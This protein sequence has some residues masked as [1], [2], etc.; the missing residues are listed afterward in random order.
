[1]HSIRLRLLTLL[2][3]A[4]GLAWLIAAWFTHLESRDEINQLFDAKLS[5]SAQVLLSTTRHDLHERVE[6]GQEYVAVHEYE[7]KVL[8]QIWYENTLLLR[9]A[10]APLSPITTT[11]AG[12]SV[13]LFRGQSWRVLTRWD[14]RKE[15]M[16][17]VAEPMSGR[18]NLAQHITY[19]L[20]MPT[21][22]VLP[23]LMFLLWVAIE[24][25]LRPLQRIKKEIKNRSPNNL[26]VVD[27]ADVPEEVLPLVGAL[28]DLLLRLE[29]AFNSERR[30]TADAAHELRTPLA[31]LKIQAQVALRS[32]DQA[33]RQTAL[34]KVLRG[35]DRATRLVEQLLIL[36]RVDPET[37]AANYQALNLHELAANA[38]KDVAKMA[39]A[40]Q[41][42]L[43]L[44]GE[45]TCLVLGDTMQLALL[46]RNLLDNAIRYSPVAGRVS[47]TLHQGPGVEL[48][49]RDTGPGIP[50]NERE[51]VLQRFYRISGSGEEGSGLG[52]SI[53][54]R[55]AT[56]HGAQLRL[57]DNEQGQGLLV[58]VNW[59][60]IQS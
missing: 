38:I 20:L 28:N 57:A 1:M 54:Q 47:V 37:V 56:L 21:F 7:Q 59:P 3:L 58:C 31:A 29:Q 49:V 55:I 39:H 30:F 46:L 11:K 60:A 34:D 27:I 18:E 44:E 4:L 19:K 23:V 9:S 15:F 8:F 43:S 42:E 41:I 24:A 40:K 51:Q 53:V 33:E 12:Y 35:V 17:Q 36:A 16:I 25:G 48:Q 14:A 5:Q 10:T 32:T 13:R 45:P 26:E 6:H 50:A 2:S 22:I 52:L